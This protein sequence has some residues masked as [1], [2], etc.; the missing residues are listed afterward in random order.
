M[1]F[2]HEIHYTQHYNFSSQI[3]ITWHVPLPVK[4]SISF[5]C[6]PSSPEMSCVALKHLGV[7][8]V[9]Y[10]GRNTCRQINKANILLSKYISIIRSASLT[11]D[12][13][14]Q[15]QVKICD[16][17]KL[18]ERVSFFVFFLQDFVLNSVV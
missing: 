1:L 3:C 13:G 15:L 14:K 16:H 17:H 6:Y 10:I 7:A 5:R 8:S 9:D 4:C 12:E 2:R 11:Q 18:F